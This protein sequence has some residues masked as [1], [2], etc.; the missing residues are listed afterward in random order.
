M[1]AFMDL[2]ESTKTLVQ[3]AQAGD[4][5]AF[6]SLVERYRERLERQIE[7]RMGPAVRARSEPADI[8]QETLVRA[9]D[10]LVHFRWQGED[11]FYRWLGSI[12]EHLIWNVSK[13]RSAEPLRLEPA[14]LHRTSAT[15]RLRRAERFDRLETA[16][17]G[18]SP[19]QREALLR[20]RI[21]G[22]SLKETARRMGRTPGAVQKLVARALLA[23]RDSFDETGSLHLPDRALRRDE[24]AHDE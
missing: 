19:D 11:S 8:V 6:E 16:V 9:L 22:L 4:T 23:L 17:A 2:E 20:V 5:A 1:T 21:D 3:A 24:E 15:Q 7:A 18:L 13:K 10:S 12:A 14:E